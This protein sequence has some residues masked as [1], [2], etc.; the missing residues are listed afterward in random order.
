[1]NR[2][3][4]ISIK[5]KWVAEI[6]S[7]RKVVE[8]RKS[9][10]N[11]D[12]PIDVYIYCTKEKPYLYSIGVEK[13]WWND[14]CFEPFADY[15]KLELSSK[16]L[17]IKDIVENGTAREYIEN[18]LN[19]K[20]IAKFRLSYVEDIG[21]SKIENV[22]EAILKDA[23]MSLNNLL[24]YSG[25]SVI[26]PDNNLYGWVINRLEIL[27]EPLK[28]N[29]FFKDNYNSLIDEGTC[30]VDCYCTSS[31]KKGKC[32]FLYCLKLRINR[33]PQSWCYAQFNNDSYVK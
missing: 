32:N 29:D 3:I 7:G 9:L 22:Q 18:I 13:W 25:T 4:L 16:K 10:P 27:E 28:L 2:V 19:G 17:K 12:L 33:P 1:M 5:S 11:C 23:C 30:D 14:G 31:N 26:T 6:L 24:E 20:I 21:N 15:R 8:I